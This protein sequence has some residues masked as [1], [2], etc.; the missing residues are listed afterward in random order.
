MNN[1]PS[2]SE[3]EQ[4]R[5]RRASLIRFGNRC[6]QMLASTKQ[7]NILRSARFLLSHPSSL[8]NSFISISLHIKIFEER[9]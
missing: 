4:K 3:N 1:Q 2:P 8:I 5:K 7:N 6:R 9:L